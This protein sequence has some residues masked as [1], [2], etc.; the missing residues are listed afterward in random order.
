MAFP[1]TPLPI[2]MWA[3]LGAN[4]ADATTWSWTE[5]TEH[6]REAEGVEIT[7]GRQDETGR[8]DTTQLTA[9]L[10]NRTGRYSPRNPSGLYAGQLV[11]GTPVQAR[12]RRIADP[13]TRTTSN[14]LGTEP[15]SGLTWSV[16]SG[17]SA[18]STNGTAALCAFAV[19]NTAATVSLPGAAAD[20]VDV[21]SIA[22]VSAVMTGGAWVH[23]TIVRFTDSSNYYRLHTEF[24]TAGTIGCKIVRI[25]GG[26]GSD[27]TAV[28]STGLAYSAGTK[29]RTRVQAIGATLR[30]KAWLDGS[31]E[32]ATWTAQ[33]ADSTVTG[34]VV[35]LYEWRVNG[36]TNVGTL[37]VTIDD[38]TMSAIRG[39][40]PV[41]E[42]PVRWDQTGANVTAPI[43]GAGI[44]RRLSQGASAL[45]SPMYRQISGYT[46]LIGYWPLE[47]GSE[48]KQAANVVALGPAAT[49]S[50]MEFGA[51]GPAGAASAVR[52]TQATPE[53]KIRGAFRPGSTTAGWQMAWSL[54]LNALPP[55][56]SRQMIAWYTSNGYLW[57]VSLDAGIYNFK[58]NDADGTNLE[59]T[60][61]SFSGAGEPNQWI[62]FRMKATASGGTVTA[63]FAW[64]VQGS[65]T[66]WG[67]TGTFS[68]TVG[69][70]TSW[71]ANGNTTM[72]DALLG[73]VFAVTTGTDNLQS[74]DA[75]RAFDGYVGESAGARIVRL[76]IE[77]AIPIALLGNAADT[78]I[79]GKQSAATALDLLRECE[80]ADQGVLHERGAGLGYL[81]RTAR[82]F[83]QSA[84]PAMALNFSSGHVAAPPEPTDDDQQLR[85]SIKLS[86]T[87]GSAAAPVQNTAS[88]ALSGLYEDELTVNLEADDVLEQHAYWRL[89]LGTSDEL[90]WP[91]IEL[92]LHRNPSLIGDW[93]KVRI[94][95][96]ITIA[97]PPSAVAGASL[98]LI[99][100]G[101]TERMST[102]AWDVTLACSPAAPWRVGRYGTS[103]AGSALTR[104]NGTMTASMGSTSLALTF[105][106]PAHRW[107]TTAGYQIRALGEVMTVTAMG[108]MAGSAPNYTQ[109]ATVTR[110]VNGVLIAHAAGESVQPY[111]ADVYGL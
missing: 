68:G 23:S 89:H 13:F 81:T 72:V 46:R 76:G 36:N 9:T 5:I 25:L 39:T 58:V 97:N 69:A 90:R 44:L 74:Y 100:E 27:L 96:R 103:R 84:T 59:D 19:A 108:S 15:D 22:S 107:S 93:C 7:V 87:G 38:Y 61:V 88:I 45:R 16:V 43:T 60:S 49:A 20:D 51:D 73:Q 86:R 35:G 2:S 31:N 101:W 62:T 111:L 55:A 80:D 105:P 102:Y 37:T 63:E 64:Y 6:V 67:I 98:D 24:T 85:N 94:G 1:Q 78:A 77:N 30:I 53:S 70:L 3:A 4:P 29:V 41:P 65:S 47:D 54:R 71:T 12:V 75:M 56:G 50:N 109:T 40:T 18:W 91:R 99:V 14:G 21:T 10:D 28:V 8:V 42:W 32:P 11:K 34:Q 79:M 52:F 92:K 106:T 95:S 26:V 66:P 17:A 33:V 110:A 83:T 104:T 82:Y 48:A 57:S